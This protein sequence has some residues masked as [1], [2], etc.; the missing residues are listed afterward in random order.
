[1]NEAIVTETP[2]VSRQDWASGR[3]G[4]ARGAGLVIRWIFAIGAGGVTATYLAGYGMFSNPGKVF[5]DPASLVMLPFVLVSLGLLISAL[6]RTWTAIRSGP[7]TLE[8][9]TIPGVIGGR[10]E[11]VIHGGPSLRQGQGVRLVLRC[12][13]MSWT[14]SSNGKSTGTSTCRWEDDRELSPAEVM[15]AIPVR[16]DIPGD[17]LA[18]AHDE[19]SGNG[20]HSVSW[21]LEALGE[22]GDFWR[23]EYEVPVFRTSATA[24]EPAPRLESLRKKFDDA[25]HGTAFAENAP[26]KVARPASTRVS[27]QSTGKGLEIVYPYRTAFLA[28]TLWVLV[29]FPLYVTPVLV[30]KWWPQMAGSVS[31]LGGLAA[32]LVFNALPAFL[33]LL[34]E[35][36]RVVV[37][38]REIVVTTGWPIFGGSRRFLLEE[39]DGV[40]ADPQFFAVLRRNASFFRRRFFLATKL[41]SHAESR[42][43]ASE[44]D[45]AVRG[46]RSGSASGTTP[47]NV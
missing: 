28:A 27:V 7:S 31:L 1:M 42:W 37:G 17:S 32:G 15:G 10:L 47:D 25:L 44:V 16:F 14:H 13:V 34:A 20:S 33:L 9:S 24:P 43:L 29:T 26:E 4:A 11:G 8:L 3:I 5:Q 18:T 40:Q 30:D 38:A 36:R 41:E 12:V 21:I 6:G 35:P 23:A 46:R 19:K 2:W 39:Y 45:L 22:P